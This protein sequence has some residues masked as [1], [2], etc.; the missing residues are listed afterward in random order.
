MVLEPV[1]CTVLISWASAGIH[2]WCKCHRSR[3]S[4]A[5]QESLNLREFLDPNAS[6]RFSVGEPAKTQMQVNRQ[7]EP[8]QTFLW[9]CRSVILIPFSW[10]C[11]WI[12]NNFWQTWNFQQLQ[13]FEMMMMTFLCG[14]WIFGPFHF[15]GYSGFPH[16]Q[17][18]GRLIRVRTLDQN[19]KSGCGCGP[20]MLRSERDTKPLPF[21]PRHT[22]KRTN[23]RINGRFWSIS[24][25]NT[26]EKILI[27][28]CRINLL[29]NGLQ[30]TEFELHQSLVFNN[31]Q[32]FMISKPWNHKHSLTRSLEWQRMQAATE[33][34][35]KQLTHRTR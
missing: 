28:L 23:Y 3:R 33:K 27:V 9:R 6:S 32:A 5:V 16:N 21:L 29:W 17:K 20:W 18:Y 19:S 35:E 22:L 15:S 24:D 26:S 31:Q 4:S 7:A 25:D 10:I 34:Q 8:L 11:W 12:K 2:F 30:M 14:V 1:R 13:Y